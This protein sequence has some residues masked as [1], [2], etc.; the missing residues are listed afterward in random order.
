MELYDA[1]L[2]ARKD[3]LREILR[4]NPH[5]NINYR[6][7]T[8]FSEPLLGMAIIE[9]GQSISISNSNRHIG[10][11]DVLLAHPRIDVNSKNQLGTTPLMH[12]CTE[13]K[14]L[15]TIKLLDH[16]DIDVNLTDNTGCTAL[17][18]AVYY[19]RKECVTWLIAIRGSE[20]HVDVSTYGFYASKHAAS[21]SKHNETMRL[22][23][24]FI[25]NK[26]AIIHEAR[27]L[28]N[29]LPGYIATTF[30]LIVSTCDGY[31]TLYD[32]EDESRETRFFRIC[33]KLPMELQMVICN[34]V[35]KSSR[36]LVLSGDS[37]PA[38]KKVLS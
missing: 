33:Q 15:Q 35:Y 6:D 17:W 18:W 3:K 27:G 26:E 11:L 28:L 10:I 21:I 5:A 31:F 37:M 13:G 1:V 12:A 23:K 30:A 29:L 20:L 16:K 38:F 36:D 22:L 7:E 8:N 25:D 4:E 2:Y 9:S 14:V 24:R 19:G 32:E 34:R